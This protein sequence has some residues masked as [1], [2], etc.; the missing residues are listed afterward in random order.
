MNP[1]PSL[2]LQQLSPLFLVGEVKASAVVKSV[3]LKPVVL[4]LWEPPVLLL[5]R[6]PFLFS[7]GLS[8]LSS[9]FSHIYSLSVV[10]GFLTVFV[11]ASQADRRLLP[12]PVN[13]SPVIPSSTTF[14][15]TTFS[16]SHRNFRL[17]AFHSNSVI[18][19]S[20][21]ASFSALRL[22]LSLT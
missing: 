11:G 19:S 14:L 22:S 2:S 17:L 1:N 16:H 9:C 6:Q 18:L 10:F 21:F 15:V 4:G 8:S 5:H 12:L 3:P 20:G 13:F 7:I